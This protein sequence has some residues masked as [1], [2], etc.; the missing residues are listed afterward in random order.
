MAK[1]KSFSHYAVKKGRKPGVYSTWPEC[2][3]QVHGFSGAV[4]KGFFSQPEAEQF[5]SAEDHKPTQEPG[6]AT[7][8]ILF[9]GD[10]EALARKKRTLVASK[11]GPPPVSDALEPTGIVLYTDGGCLGNP[12]PGGYGVIL[13]DG[14]NRTELSGGFRRTTNNRMELTACIVGLQALEKPSSVA[15]YTDSRYLANSIEKGW[16]KRWRANRWRRGDE[17][18]PNAD[19][20]KTMLE[21][22]EKHRVSFHWVKGHAGHTENERCDQLSVQ[23]SQGRNLPPDTGYEEREQAGKPGASIDLF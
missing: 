16:A 11:G 15:V 23:S 21:L 12:G 10:R 14:P 22:C 6:E 1:K 18:V 4:Y 2:F 19:L 13:V 3:A 8:A 20:W 7:Q 5:V 9:S 17:T